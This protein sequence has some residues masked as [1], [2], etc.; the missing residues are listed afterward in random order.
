MKENQRFKQLRLNYLNKK[1]KQKTKQK[2]TK[3]TQKVQLRLIIRVFISSIRVGAV[4]SVLE[5][6]TV[7]WLMSF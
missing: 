3:T 7:F 1:N 2:K 6:L 5:R 4:S